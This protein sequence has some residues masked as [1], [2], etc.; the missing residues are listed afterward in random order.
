[1]V[2]ILITKTSPSPS[3]TARIVALSSGNATIQEAYGSK[4]GPTRWA[5]FFLFMGILLCGAF[6]FPPNIWSRFMH[7]LGTVHNHDENDGSGK[8][9]GTPSIWDLNQVERTHPIHIPFGSR[10]IATSCIQPIFQGYVSFLDIIQWCGV[11]GLVFLIFF[12]RQEFM[13]CKE[14]VVWATVSQVQDTF[15]FLRRHVNN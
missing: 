7:S 10:Q 6:V 3:S 4:Q 9:K 12:I 1:M 13:R 8:W 2:R 14:R 15:G 5:K 11:V